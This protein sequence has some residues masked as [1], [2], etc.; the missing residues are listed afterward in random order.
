[1]QYA[2]LKFAIPLNMPEPGLGVL[3]ENFTR[4]R[5]GLRPRGMISNINEALTSAVFPDGSSAGNFDDVAADEV[6]TAQSA[7]HAL[8]VVGGVSADLWGAGARRV[9]RVE[10]IH[11]KLT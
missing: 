5:P 6:A 4:G 7:Q 3:V 1:M 11:V 10:A 2:S 8:G 9:D